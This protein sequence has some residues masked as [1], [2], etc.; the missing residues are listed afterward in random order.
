MSGDLGIGLVGCGRLA[1][2]GYVPALRAARGVRLVAVADPDPD[3]R[4]QV[5][6]LANE[7]GHTVRLGAGAADLLEGPLD[8]IVLATPATAH[9]VDAARAAV[10]GVPALVEKPPAPD[11]ASAADLAALTPAPRLGFNRRFDPRATRLR[12]VARAAGWVDVEIVLHYR[13]RSWR[14]HTITDDALLDLGPHVV[15]LARWITDDEVVAV[16][17]ETVTDRAAVL[18]LELTHGRARVACATDRPHREQVVLR[19]AGGRRLVDDRVGGLAAGLQARVTG[20]GRPHPLA[21]SLTAQ[22]EAWGAVLRGGTAPTLGTA[23]DGVA[24]M[25]ALDAA[26]ASARDGGVRTPVTS[27]ATSTPA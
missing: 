26:R 3:R 1:E 27:T 21:A 15:D 9:V 6:A 25:A 24:V 12:E 8:G 5:A 17:A 22:V 10:A 19:S 23:R 18:D 7:D 2:L 13:R 4:A 20:R 14:A 16:T 11:A